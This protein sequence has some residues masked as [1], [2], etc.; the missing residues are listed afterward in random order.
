M[1]K[2]ELRSQLK[3]KRLNVSK[4]ERAS[5]SKR[6]CTRLEQLKWTN[7]KLLH[8]YEPILSLNEVDITSFVQVLQ[9]KRPD[10]QIYTS[11]KVDSAWQIVSWEKHIAVTQLLQFDAVIVPMLGF[12]TSLHRIG[13]GGGYYDTFLASQPQ[14]SKIGVSYEIGKMATI[15]VEN[16]DIPLDK[17]ITESQVY[18]PVR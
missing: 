13:Y 6:I 2:S 14:A 12:D 11:R 10:I 3:L 16:H 9:L 15:P 1:H 7:V 18:L 8:C 5:L 4:A 17:I